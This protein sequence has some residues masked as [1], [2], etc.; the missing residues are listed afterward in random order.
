MKRKDYEAALEP[1]A[2]EPV[3]MACWA[4]AP[5]ARVVVVFEGRDTT[6]KGGAITAVR[7]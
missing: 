6:G 5:R 4:K 2:L 3:S 7:A 1:L